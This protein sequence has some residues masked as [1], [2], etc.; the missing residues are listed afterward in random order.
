MKITNFKEL[1]NPLV[2]KGYNGKIISILYYSTHMQYEKVNVDGKM[3]IRNS[4]HSTP[5][6]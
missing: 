6:F 3:R 5:R 4:K 1:K 2:R